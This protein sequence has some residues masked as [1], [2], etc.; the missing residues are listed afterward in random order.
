MKFTAI[1]DSVLRPGTINDVTI[2]GNP[3][4]LCVMLVGPRV[5]FFQTVKNRVAGAFGDIPAVGRRFSVIPVS[6]VATD[7]W[8]PKMVVEGALRRRVAQARV[9]VVPFVL[10]SVELVGIKSVEYPAT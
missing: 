9:H 1:E 3:N 7:A 10:N 8:G 6:L 2:F 4:D 5:A